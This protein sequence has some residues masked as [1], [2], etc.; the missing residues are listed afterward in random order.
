MNE[1]FSDH[2]ARREN[3]LTRLD[4]R[5]K[6]IFVVVAIL[7]VVSAA[8][9]YAP[10]IVILL[11]LASLFTIRIPFKI[12]CSRLAAPFGI[13]VTIIF[14][15]IFFYREGFRDGFLMM[16]KIIG[17]TSLVLFLSMTTSVDKLL[18]ASRW[19]K[20][21][22]TWVE[23]CLLAYRYIFVLM[24]DAVTVFDAQRIRLGYIGLPRALRSIGTLAGTIIIRA[25]DQ[26]IATYEA[27]ML[28]GYKGHAE[29]LS[30]EDRLMLKDAVAAFVFIAILASLLILNHTFKI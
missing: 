18:A 2:F 21:P 22:G 3:L 6:T 13:A 10:L 4:A 5:I 27:M 29:I 26:S 11:S 20:V 12:I 14:I 9:P 1:I 7:T 16:S 17:S 30:T 28:R 15:K 24:E 25:Y 23:I 8:A 19:F